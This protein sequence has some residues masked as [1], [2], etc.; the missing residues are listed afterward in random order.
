VVR[1][2]LNILGKSD[3]LIRFVE[4]RPGHDRRYA[5]NYALAEKELGYAPQWDFS[6]GL[7]ATAAWYARNATWLD[8]VESGAYRSFMQAWYG[9]RLED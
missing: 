4:D 6:A 5:M 7:A 2:L 3:S 9:S 8:E 1:A